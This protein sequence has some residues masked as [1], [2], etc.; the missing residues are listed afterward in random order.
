MRSPNVTKV[1]TLSDLDDKKPLAVKVGDVPVVLV[2]DGDEV[3]ALRDEC[4]HAFQPLSLGEVTNKGLECWL[5]GACFDLRTG[6]P[7]APPG[8]EPVEV[9]AVRVDGEDVFVDPGT[10]VN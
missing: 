3:H 9:Y 2:R 7:C 8:I 6:A 5:H 1:C 4:S 10:T